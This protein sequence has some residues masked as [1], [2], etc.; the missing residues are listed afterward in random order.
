[1]EKEEYL[2]LDSDAIEALDKTVVEMILLGFTPAELA[3]T[4]FS[5]FEI[6]EAAD[7]TGA[8]SVE[9][10]KGVPG[11]TAS[12]LQQSG[13]SANA[14]REAG[15]S[16]SQLRAGGYSSSEVEA[17]AAFAPATTSSTTTVVIIVAVFVILVVV[18]FTIVYTKRV[19]TVVANPMAPLSFENPMYEAGG[20]RSSNSYDGGDVG[21]YMDVPSALPQQSGYMDVS[22]GAGNRPAADEDSDEEV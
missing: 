14:A 2:R 16:E 3:T 17:S 5:A 13:F 20:G 12:K 21:G 6:A 11:M 18:I 10:L 8:F 4:G 9:E 19:A 22:P 15:Y 1:M 7:E